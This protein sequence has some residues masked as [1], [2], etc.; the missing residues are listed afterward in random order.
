MNERSS[1]EP[2]QAAIAFHLSLLVLFR[3]R[4]VSCTDRPQVKK[5][6][7]SKNLNGEYV[8]TGKMA[9]GFGNLETG[10]SL[11]FGSVKKNYLASTTMQA[12]L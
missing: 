2:R 10:R 3:L 1:L 5:L 12:L 7:Q 11:L 6:R 8:R 9:E 4:I